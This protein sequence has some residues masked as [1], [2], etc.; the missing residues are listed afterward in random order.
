VRL[1][2]NLRARCGGIVAPARQIE[3]RHISAIRFGYIGTQ[4]ATQS[5]D[6]DHERR[7]AW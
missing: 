2:F 6:L 4:E 7:I 5:L 3:A 1:V